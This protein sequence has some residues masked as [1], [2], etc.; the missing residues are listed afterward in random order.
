MSGGWISLGVCIPVEFT[1]LAATMEEIDIHRDMRVCVCVKR[2]P[3]AKYF[4]DHHETSKPMSRLPNES[5]LSIESIS[6]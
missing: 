4:I 3:S 5:T 2:E 1:L 6:T